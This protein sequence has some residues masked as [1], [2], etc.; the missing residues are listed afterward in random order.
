[1]CTSRT[2]TTPKHKVSHL[3]FLTWVAYSR[4]YA[5]TMDDVRRRTC[6][7]IECEKSFI[8]EEAMLQHVYECPRLSKGMYRCSGCGQEER[9]SRFHTNG[10]HDLH[11]GKDKLF[12]VANSLRLAKKIFSPHGPKGR[13]VVESQP[14]RREIITQEHVELH[15][16]SGASDAKVSELDTATSLTEL[17]TAWR[18]NPHGYIQELQGCD[19]PAELRGN[20]QYICEPLQDGPAELAC[21]DYT[22][23]LDSRQD[24]NWGP[25]ESYVTNR[26][27]NTE[28]S[29]H[30]QCSHIWVSP[31]PFGNESIRELRLQIPSADR[32]ATTLGGDDIHQFQHKARFITGP[33]RCYKNIDS[34]GILAEAS[35]PDNTQEPPTTL[36]V[37]PAE[38]YTSTGSL[39]GHSSGTGSMLS[40]L[41]P[42]T[43]AIGSDIE[44]ESS[45]SFVT[46]ERKPGSELTFSEL[47]YLGLLTAAGISNSSIPELGDFAFGTQVHAEHHLP[48]TMSREK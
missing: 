21:Y 24:S 13:R 5:P 38:S 47:E 27:E 31:L 1:M 9:I 34:A 39:S 6:P 4:K 46:L 36:P 2:C 14:L 32:S 18:D 7:L 30:R 40:P 26:I 37:S 41:T 33:P 19:L 48:S 10:C 8:N 45:Q 23:L 16:I 29:V 42:S 28:H 22:N 44:A 35:S 11:P 3:R 12:T 25:T 15:E 17:D 20:H 43:P